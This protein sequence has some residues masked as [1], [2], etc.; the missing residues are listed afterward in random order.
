MAE[1]KLANPKTPPTP[2]K[3]SRKNPQPPSGMQAE[4]IVVL[5]HLLTAIGFEIDEN[6]VKGRTFGETSRQAL[7]RLQLLLGLEPTGLTSENMS[8]ILN[9]ARQR[10]NVSLALP[11][12][13]QPAGTDKYWIEGILTDADG[14]PLAG[15]TV[16]ADACG[17]RKNVEIGRSKSDR[18][19]HYRI[20]QGAA[21]NKAQIT[22]TI[23]QSAAPN[24][25]LRVISQEGTTLYTSAI[26]FQAACG[27]NFPIALGGVAHN[28]PS[29]FSVL[30]TAF[31]AVLG[32]LPADE[33]VEDSNFQD[34]TFLAGQTGFNKK[35]IAFY[36]VAVRLAN[37]TGLPAEFF[38][39]LFSQKVPADGSAVVLA[40]TS[41]A[42]NFEFNAQRLLKSIL[43]A[44][45]L[46]LA[47]ALNEA[48]NKNILPGSYGARMQK[49]LARL[50]P[51]RTKSA[52][53][54]SWGMG[55]TPIGALLGAAA[56]APEK[57]NKFIS[58]FSAKINTK[59]DFWNELCANP[60]FTK[61]DVASL[62]FSI[63]IGKH[64]KGHLP[65]VNKLIEMRQ[66]GKIKTSSDLARLSADDWKTLLN[67]TTDGQPV[68]VPPGFIL[69]D[70]QSA[71]DNYAH[72]LEHNFEHA[73]PTTA[74][75]AR[76][77]EDQRCPI[78]NKAALID[79]L[80]A[81]PNFNLL[82]T[83]VDRYLKENSSAIS[84]SEREGL[85]NS[86]Y[87]CKR[88]I[89]LASR[90]AAVKPLIE[91]GIL[92]S[93]PIYAM[94]RSQ[95]I[96]KYQGH[97]EIG[98][99]EAANIYA[100]AEQTYALAFNLAMNNQ[101]IILRGNPASIRQVDTLKLQK[102]LR[103]Y[104]NIETL[105][106][107]LD[108][109]ECDP[110]R[111]VLSPAA[112]LVDLLNFLS[113]RSAS[114]QSGATAPG[115]GTLR[116]SPSVLDIL[117]QRRPDL[118][119]IKLNAPNT[120]TILPYIDLVNELLEEAVAAPAPANPQTPTAAQR[121]TTLTS[122]ELNA[123]P[124]YVNYQAYDKLKNAVFPWSLP[125][126]L[127]LYEGRA[128]LGQLGVDRVQLMQ[129]FL[130]PTDDVSKNARYV[131]EA[132]EGLG[133][134]MAEADIII[135]NT[136]NPAWKYWNL[137]RNTNSISDPVDQTITYTGSWIAVLSNVRILLSRSGLTFN[138][139]KELLN[140][141]Y[142]N[143]RASL[144]LQIDPTDL[145][146]IDNMKITGFDEDPDALDRIHRFVRLMRRLNWDVYTLDSA[147]SNLPLITKDNTDKLKNT[148][149]LRQL[150]AV[151]QAMLRF[152]INAS[153]AV[154]LWGGIE[155]R[156]IS[157]FPN[158]GSFRYSLYHDLFQNNVVLN[159]VDPA[160]DLNAAGTQLQV[161][162]PAFNDDP[163]FASHLPTLTA[164]LEISGSDLTQLAQLP[165]CSHMYLEHLAA[166][167]RHVILARGLGLSIQE[168]ITLKG[169][170]ETEQSKAPY[171]PF[172]PT[173][174]ELLQLFCDTVDKIRSTNFSIIELDYLLRHNFEKTSG[175]AP[176]DV[177]IGTLLKS[178]LDGLNTIAAE[179][180][181]NSDPTGTE[182]GKRLASV[183]SPADVA[184]IMQILAEDTPSD[185]DNIISS[186]LSQYM[187]ASFTTA[188]LLALPDA[189]ARYELVL[190]GL[191]AYFRQAQGTNFVI[192][193]LS[194]ALSLPIVTTKSLLT[195]W[196]QTQADPTQKIIKDF[197]VLLDV[198][199]NPSSNNYPNTITTDEKG[200]NTIDNSSV[201]F[202]PYFDYYKALDKAAKIINSFEF[203]SDETAWLFLNGINKGWLDPSKLP[204]QYQDAP[205][206]RFLQWLRL[207]DAVMVKTTLP[208]DGTPFTLLMD[209]ASN[210]ADKQSYLMALE[211][212]TQWPTQNLQVLCGKSDDP[213]DT[214]L[215]SLRY[216]DDY[217]SEQAL[218]KLMPAFTMLQLLGTS[219]D[220]VA[221]WLK[222]WLTSADAN[223]IKQNLKAK[224]TN[225]QWLQTAKQLRDPLRELQRDALVSYLLVH[226]PL[227][228]TPW[229]DANDVY[230]YFLID[231][232]MSACQ[233]TTRIVQ[234]NSTV[235]LFVLRCLLNLETEV[236]VDASIDTDW[237]QWQWMN[238]Y[239]LWVANRKVFLYPENYIEPSL[240]K[241]KSPLIS[242]LEND[243]LQNEV[244]DDIAEDALQ[245]YLEQL[246]ALARLQVA[247]LY[248]SE[249]QPQASDQI[250]ISVNPASVQIKQGE[251]TQFTAVV[252]GAINV[253]VIWKALGATIDDYGKFTAPDKVGTY[254]VTATSIEDPTK[255][256]AATVQ[257]VNPVSVT[258]TPGS[259]ILG[260]NQKQKF[261]AK[262]SGSS[263]QKV[264]W[265]TTAT[266]ALG[267]IDAQ[268]TFTAPSQVGPFQV[269]AT[270]A[271]DPTKS[272]TA[273]VTVKFT[274]SITGPTIVAPGSSHTYTANISPAG[275]ATGA[276]YDWGISS[277][278]LG[279]VT[280]VS[281]TYPSTVWKAGIDDSQNGRLTVHVTNQGITAEGSKQIII[282]KADANTGN[283]N[284]PPF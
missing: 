260:G 39:G 48:I 266:S 79:F 269:T 216:P 187:Q 122:D 150:F 121:Q 113:W 86:L 80:N 160:F 55:K 201:S 51:I 243:L 12:T 227:E 279:N 165:E 178:I 106:G 23:S 117:N 206:G 251:S 259:V 69:T 186:A 234:A 168:L 144:Q 22:P 207:V 197:L 78:S 209:V 252:S 102:E 233:G 149:F 60:D 177:T 195:E 172:D 140:T 7:R 74:F 2:K 104:P 112:Y 56:I 24:L 198:E 277:T 73:Y 99:V 284:N 58:L 44:S 200:I 108:L 176:D 281:G 210:G 35:Q 167:Y 67:S 181:F 164:A 219:A 218:A 4:D 282:N 89:K 274:V 98:A 114:S 239:Q 264:T 64:T 36:S 196:F 20:E 147:I 276:H 199:R 265:S 103:D 3:T 116:P 131:F 170:F 137:D 248:Y 211:N 127:P 88:M 235:Q 271:A 26:H 192:Q 70:Q 37:D 42:I 105:F 16:I 215:L 153:S 163:A 270:S 109:C 148:L 169:L 49:D 33:I 225:E 32:K 228:I 61:E 132:V 174:P 115:Q 182:T 232:E 76:L 283:N 50:E 175:V 75:S 205:N 247:G 13:R 57:Q 72:F 6:E 77:A 272:A 34:I 71:I 157:A 110:S 96:R 27:T 229:N 263:N 180:I 268:G 249:V 94:G 59:Q 8:A 246:D 214:G 15:A 245:K 120:F 223:N 152:Q 226:P 194:N 280:P 189:E 267:T 83:N 41:Q 257:V 85:R 31:A 92:S 97:P 242:D 162:G 146:K 19:G 190:K 159:P 222:F 91:D 25:Q 63:N 139:L 62:K 145:Y 100:K 166:L 65:L 129:V 1:K 188:D 256:A 230:A 10:L 193:Q 212:R 143:P 118:K 18:Q 68:G 142:I 151:K 9:A 101:A 28:T 11:D 87:I 254:T 66:L 119:Q 250:S 52:S 156:T 258:I 203:S 81:N 238:R 124:Q 184:S 240:R 158:P 135:G 111:S 134:S 138:T 5:H 29:E 95:F 224:Y 221:G 213:S 275:N 237:Q 136:S 47:H 191:L 173:R 17:F 43:A 220:D 273:T 236:S 204:L 171:D 179:N 253:A 125:F 161:V 107:P 14:L 45:N 133:L 123:N 126:D 84:G 141:A 185:P 40:T 93:Q 155:T 183:L 46:V 38:Y 21:K 262:V 231:V 217:A 53:S 255:S 130:N 128:Y 278:A 154:A 54:T 208:S 30:K 241:D 244:T 202:N 82:N 90:Y 261:T